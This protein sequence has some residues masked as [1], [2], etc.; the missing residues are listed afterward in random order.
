MADN[1]CIVSKLKIILL[2]D[3]AVGKTSI[4]TS[5]RELEFLENQ[6]VAA[7]LTQ[8]TIGIDFFSKIV[9]KNKCYYKLQFWDT[10]G[11]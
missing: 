2:G 1:T 8:P 10:A 5:I 7:C 3:P 9:T 6:E 4:V 11:Q